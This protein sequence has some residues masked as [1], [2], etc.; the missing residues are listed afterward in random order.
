MNITRP[1]KAHELAKRIKECRKE[2]AMRFLE[3]G[4]LFKEVRDEELYKELDCESFTEFIADPEISFSR[5]T[6]YSFIEI[7][8]KYTLRLKVSQEYLL[9]IG[10]G[11]LRIINPVVEENPDEWLGKARA[12]SRSDLISEVR[13]HQGIKP[14][15]SLPITLEGYPYAPDLASHDSYLEWVRK[16]PCIICERKEA[17]PHHFPRTKGAGAEEWKVIP[18]CVPCHSEA[19]QNPK[20]WLW[21]NRIQI[22]DYFYGLVKENQN[23]QKQIAR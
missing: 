8:E 22:F 1:E 5:S 7:Y 20:E 15:F 21:G 3:L 13:E 16:S 17:F 11:K 2:V 12:L 4:K 10:H 23:D 9:D 6:V 14:S 19:H 18:L